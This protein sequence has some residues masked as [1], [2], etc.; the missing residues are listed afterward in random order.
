LSATNAFDR[1]AEAGES[2]KSGVCSDDGW[3]AA[4]SRAGDEWEGYCW[5]DCGIDC[6]AAED[7]AQSDGEKKR[8]RKSQQ[9]NR[10]KGERPEG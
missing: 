6:T 2:M 4:A 8:L 5:L 10:S 1:L 3:Y 9:L 7:I